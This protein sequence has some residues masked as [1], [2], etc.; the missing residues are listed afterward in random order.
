MPRVRAPALG[1]D[2]QYLQAPLATLRR[3]PAKQ[4]RAMTLPVAII[5]G[6]TLAAII[7]L[8]GTVVSRIND[9]E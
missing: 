5:L 1:N 2:L 3:D 9:K 8:A 7:L 4:A 6:V